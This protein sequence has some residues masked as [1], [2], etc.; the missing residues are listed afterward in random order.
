MRRQLVGT[1]SHLRSSFLNQLDG[2]FACLT[3]FNLGLLI[4]SSSQHLTECVDKWKEH[5]FLIH[6][7]ILFVFC[8]TPVT[9]GLAELCNLQSTL[10]YVFCK[11]HKVK[12][13][14]SEEC[15]ESQHEYFISRPH[16]ICLCYKEV[17]QKWG[18]QPPLRLWYWQLQNVWE[19]WIRSRNLELTLVLFD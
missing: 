19:I 17:P 11:T 4:C 9:K 13:E 14:F 3:V 15:I 7:S 8:A 10:M 18:T 5:W 1:N 16:Y 2:K 12:I 6:K